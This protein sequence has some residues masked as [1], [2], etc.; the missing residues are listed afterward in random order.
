MRDDTFSHPQYITLQI[1]IINDN[2]RN[3][4]FYGNGGAET[5][6]AR[7]LR[8]SEDD[9]IL[10]VPLIGASERN[11]DLANNPRVSYIPLGANSGLGIVGA[12]MK[13]SRM[14]VLKGQESF[15]AGCIM[16]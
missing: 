8:V 13:L 11:R 16:R 10:V 5:M 4:Q 15:C 7:L 12:T 14:I 1:N 6:L 9:R 2:A 3:N